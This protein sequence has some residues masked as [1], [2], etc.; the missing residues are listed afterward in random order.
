MVLWKFTFLIL[1][2]FS[3]LTTGSLALFRATLNFILALKRLLGNS[4]GAA[5][6]SVAAQ[7]HSTDSMD[8]AFGALA[9]LT[10]Y[11]NAFACDTALERKLELSKNISFATMFALNAM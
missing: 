7:N 5:S 8:R 1:R 3:E 6:G 2:S 10:S 4:L 9:D 11:P